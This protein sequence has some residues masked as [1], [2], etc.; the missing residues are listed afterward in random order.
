MLLVYKISKKRK[1]V[2]YNMCNVYVMRAMSAVDVIS[3]MM[4]MDTTWNDEE[5]LPLLKRV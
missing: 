4:V 2:L 1:L 3:N 5:E